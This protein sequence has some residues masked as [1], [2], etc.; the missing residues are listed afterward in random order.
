MKVKF[1]R[2]E[3]ADELVGHLSLLDISSIAVAV[4]THEGEP[5]IIFNNTDQLEAL[6]HQV[7][8]AADNLPVDVE[9]I[10]HETLEDTGHDI[11]DMHGGVNSRGAES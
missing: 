11:D 7:K 4:Q 2:F 6:L 1:L 3:D 9:I 5:L 10:S 8:E